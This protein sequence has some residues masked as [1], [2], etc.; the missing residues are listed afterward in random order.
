[1]QFIP[2]QVITP[3]VTFD[4]L[5]MQLLRKWLIEERGIAQYIDKSLWED[6]YEQDKGEF[7]VRHIYTT[8]YDE[9]KTKQKEHI[10]TEIRIL[11]FNGITTK[12]GHFNDLKEITDYFRANGLYND[13][14]YEVNRKE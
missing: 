1:M 11:E 6:L 9:Y 14:I 7:E 3:K 8:S 10:K 13:K 2:E 5:E 4:K 12:I